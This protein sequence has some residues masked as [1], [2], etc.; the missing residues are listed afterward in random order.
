[1]NFEDKL[2]RIDEALKQAEKR[3]LTLCGKV[4]VIKSLAISKIT[5][6]AMC[7]AVPDGIIKQV[8]HT[9]FRFLWRKRD[10][11]QRRVLLIN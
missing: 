3:N 9:I 5:Y 10:H 7:L 2:T 4:C 1:M 11:I 6:V 8:D